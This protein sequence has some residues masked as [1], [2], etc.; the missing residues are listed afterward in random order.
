[1][2]EGRSEV[3]MKSETKKVLENEVL[4]LA[5]DIAAQEEDLKRL[6]KEYKILS[7]A[8]AGLSA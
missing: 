3:L 7:T 6:K 8:L 2:P 5:K 1:M 4:K